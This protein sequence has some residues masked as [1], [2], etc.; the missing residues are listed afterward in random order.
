M[1]L[2]GF[3]SLAVLPV[4]PANNSR[5]SDQYAESRRN[6]TA[7][8]HQCRTS[9]TPGGGL[10]GSQFP[11]HR[12]P[13]A[14]EKLWTLPCM[15]YSYFDPVGGKIFFYLYDHTKSNLRSIPIIARKLFQHVYDQDNQY[16]HGHTLP[17]SNSGSYQGF[18]HKTHALLP[19]F[20]TYTTRLVYNCPL[21]P[22]NTSLLSLRHPHINK[23]HAVVRVFTSGKRL[24]FTC[25]YILQ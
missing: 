5:D 1:L 6:L 19:I 9:G 7:G 24:D 10:N 22:N 12:C 17:S 15:K 2:Y 20:T 13:G 4:S 23:T 11:A 14:S 8:G 3:L 16:K 21:V 18:K 25:D